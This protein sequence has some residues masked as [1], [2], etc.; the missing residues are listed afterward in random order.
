MGSVCQSWV[1]FCVYCV[2]MYWLPIFQWD[3]FCVPERGNFLRV[4]YLYVLVTYISV[5]CVCVPELGNFLRCTVSLCIGYLYFS[6]MLSA[7]QS[8]VTSCVYC[9]SMYWLP[10]FQW[11]AF[12][13]P[14]LGNFLCVL[15][16]YV[17]VTY[18]SVG[19]V[20][21]ARAG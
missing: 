19:C 3:A 14:E 7:C 9:M 8:W 21:S 13:V 12:C 4:L 16:V 6:G 10:I 17:V 20:L 15:Y 2:C 1:T 18:I 5:G 11:D